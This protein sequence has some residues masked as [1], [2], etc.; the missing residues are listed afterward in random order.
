MLVKRF[1]GYIEKVTLIDH[2]FALKCIDI[3]KRNYIQLLGVK[4]LITAFC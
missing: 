3:V 4:G 2:L 1:W